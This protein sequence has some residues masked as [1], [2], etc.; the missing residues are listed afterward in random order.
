MVRPLQDGSPKILHWPRLKPCERRSAA[1]LFASITLSLTVQMRYSPFRKLLPQQKTA[2]K[3]RGEP[4]AY[5][6]NLSILTITRLSALTWYQLF[7]QTLK[8]QDGGKPMT[9]CSCSAFGLHL[10]KR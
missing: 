10:F 8:R 2:Q 4:L 5:T 1:L 6:P 9:L 3:Q 7:W